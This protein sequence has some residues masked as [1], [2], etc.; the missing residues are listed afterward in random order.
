MCCK[1]KDGKKFSLP[2]NSMINVKKVCFEKVVLHINIV[3]KQIVKKVVQLK[4][5]KHS[6]KKK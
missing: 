4:I 1:R 2:E 5:K 6:S 3:G